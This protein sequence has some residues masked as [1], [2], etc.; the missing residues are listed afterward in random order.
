MGGKEVLCTQARNYLLGR[1]LLGATEKV[2]TV[3]ALLRLMLLAPKHLPRL[4]AIV[5]LFTKYGLRDVA[6]QQGLLAIGADEDEELPPEA[7]ADREAHAAGF[8]RRLIELGPAYVKLGQVLSTRPDILPPA[9]CLHRSLRLT[10]SGR[11]RTILRCRG[12]SVTCPR[13]SS[14]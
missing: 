12:R 7:V 10:P 6:R 5:G 11:S 4:A 14:S 1:R 2:G 3:H 9:S 13:T 8:K